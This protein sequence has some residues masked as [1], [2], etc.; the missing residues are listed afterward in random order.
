MENLLDT[1]TLQ[2]DKEKNLTKKMN[3]K[4]ANLKKFQDMTHGKKKV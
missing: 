1:K 4:K 2:D 3:G